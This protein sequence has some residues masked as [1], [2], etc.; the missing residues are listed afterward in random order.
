MSFFCTSRLRDTLGRPPFADAVADF[1]PKENAFICAEQ[2]R[3]ELG[4]VRGH[5][6]CSARLIAV[7]AEFPYFISAGFGKSPCG[8]RI[9][10]GQLRLSRAKRAELRSFDCHLR[11]RADNRAAASIVI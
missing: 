4:F 2:A 11:T 3:C 8:N 1:L 9:R 10:T 5:G 7:A 6:S